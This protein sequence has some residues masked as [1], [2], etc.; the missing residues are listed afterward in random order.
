MQRIT[1]DMLGIISY[2]YS[3]NTVPKA[4]KLSQKKVW[5]DSKK[6]MTSRSTECSYLIDMTGKLYSQNFS[7]VGPY[8]RSEQGPH[9]LT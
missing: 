4:Q 6:Q 1:K 3:I 7:N 2:A 8:T 5:N 9:R